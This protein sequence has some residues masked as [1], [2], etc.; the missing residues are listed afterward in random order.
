MI[1]FTSEGVLRICFIKDTFYVVLSLTVLCVSS[2]AYLFPKF[3][4][5]Q[6]KFVLSRIFET[7]FF[8]H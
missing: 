8:V 2:F 4:G 3:K 7:C 1:N 6:Q 5:R